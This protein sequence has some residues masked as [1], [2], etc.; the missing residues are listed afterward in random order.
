MTAR[1]YVDV[2]YENLIRGTALDNDQQNTLKQSMAEAAR[3]YA[4]KF[5]SEQLVTMQQ[6][7]GK[8][9]ELK[10]NA[11]PV[12]KLPEFKKVVANEAYRCLNEFAEEAGMI[13]HRSHLCGKEV[14]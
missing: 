3:K 11:L 6:V 2:E 14:S 8:G 4:T 13:Y 7:I 12:A 9:L 1:Q 5:Y 10:L